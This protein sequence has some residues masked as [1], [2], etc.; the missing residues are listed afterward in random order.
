V[1]KLETAFERALERFSVTLRDGTTVNDLACASASLVE[2]VWLN[3]CLT[4]RHPFDDAEPI[5]T[6]LRR[7][8]RLL[9][10]GATLDR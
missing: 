7:G 4:D 5:A 6:V 10:R 9:W 3:Q 2:G 8:G 1:R